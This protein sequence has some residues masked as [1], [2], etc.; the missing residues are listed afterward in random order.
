MQQM[1]HEGSIK[2]STASLQDFVSKLFKLLKDFSSGSVQSLGNG[3]L[4]VQRQ[5]C[6][7]LTQITVD[8]VL[9]WKITRT[10]RQMLTATQRRMLLPE[11]TL[12][13]DSSQLKMCDLK[14]ISRC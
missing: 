7:L 12:Y 6:K 11:I 3:A 13:E 2:D 9:D 5:R 4:L 1:V 8:D 14:Y 10:V